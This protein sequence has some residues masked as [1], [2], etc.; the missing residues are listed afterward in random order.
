MMRMWLVVSLVRVGVIAAPL[1]SAVHP[2]EGSG[3]RPDP[4]LSAQLTR[5]S[6]AFRDSDVTSLRSSL[7]PR[8]KIDVDFRGVSGGQGSYGRGQ[9]EVI[10]SR[11]FRDFETRDLVFGDGDVTVSGTQTAFARGRWSRK[12]RAGGPEEADSLTLML[13][14][15]SGDWRIFEIRSSR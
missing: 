14:Q 8:G 5:V 9:L 11:I 3:P 13:H 12:P 10:F 7:S 15:E 2:L 4:R 6:K 1:A